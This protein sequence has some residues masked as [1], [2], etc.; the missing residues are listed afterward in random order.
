MPLSG[1]ENYVVDARRTS[2]HNDAEFH[3]AEDQD[4]ESLGGPQDSN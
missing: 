4:E 2:I 1:I 3:I